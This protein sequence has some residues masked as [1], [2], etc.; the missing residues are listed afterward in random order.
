[1][2]NLS[3][4]LPY[5]PQTGHVVTDQDSPTVTTSP[6]LQAVL[7]QTSLAQKV[8]FQYNAEGWY[9]GPGIARESPREPGTFISPPNSVDLQPPTEIDSGCWPRWNGHLWLSARP[10]NQESRTVMQTIRDFLRN[11]PLLQYIIK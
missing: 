5:D 2:P 9:I 11:N 10:Q 4:N 7:E 6:A 3:A 1:M 8:V